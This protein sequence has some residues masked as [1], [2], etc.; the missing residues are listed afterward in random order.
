MVLHG[1]KTAI[2]ESEGL[3]FSSDRQKGLDE[4]VQVVYPR[5][6]HRECIAHLYG[7]FKKKFRG[8]CY[9]D[10]LWAAAKAYTPN[11][12]ET[13]IAKGLGQYEVLWSDEFS[14]EVIGPQ[15]RFEVRLHETQCSCRLWQ[16]KRCA[17][18]SL[19]WQ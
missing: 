18:H 7:N 6:E 10:N 14:A 13:S 16:V 5:V 9:R 4:A 3:V 19:Q 15:S 11:V 1:L 12:Y 17:M 2:G 8:D